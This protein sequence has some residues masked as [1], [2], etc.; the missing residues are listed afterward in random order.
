MYQIRRKE[1]ITLVFGLWRRLQSHRHLLSRNCWILKCDEAAFDP[2]GLSNSGRGSAK[3]A[4]A[5]MDKAI[6]ILATMTRR[7]L[8]CFRKGTLANSGI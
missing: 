5:Q 6:D 3:Y 1:S 8:F 4:I 7:D 2:D